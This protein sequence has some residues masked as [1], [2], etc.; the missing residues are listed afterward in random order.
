M[1]SNEGPK[2]GASRREVLSKIPSLS[3]RLRFPTGRDDAPAFG[4][5]SAHVRLLF[6]LRSVL[7][8]SRKRIALSLRTY[9]ERSVS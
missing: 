6:G 9:D 5:C 1:N 3:L 2:N 7:P 4:L 8:S